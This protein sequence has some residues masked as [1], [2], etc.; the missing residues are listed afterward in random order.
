MIVLYLNPRVTQ[1]THIKKESFIYAVPLSKP[2]LVMFYSTEEIGFTYGLL[3]TTLATSWGYI[4]VF[5][6]KLIKNTCTQENSSKI[7]KKK[8][9]HSQFYSNFPKFLANMLIASKNVCCLLYIMVTV[10]STDSL[11]FFIIL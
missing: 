6:I 1:S 3:C 5:K 2:W 8:M 10:S 7:K 11:F 4:I 9:N